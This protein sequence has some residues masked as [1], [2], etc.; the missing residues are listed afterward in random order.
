MTQLALAQT[1]IATCPYFDFLDDGDNHCNNYD[2]APTGY[3]PLGE[4]SD[5][6]QYQL[7]TVSGPY[8]DTVT[9]AEQSIPSLPKFM[10]S[11]QR[12]SGKLFNGFAPA[13]VAV[14]LGE[15][16]STTKLLTAEDVRRRLGVPSGTR[17][18][19]LAYGKD[20]LIENI[21]PR[22]R[23][24][25]RR[26][27]ELRFDL[28]TSINYSIWDNHPHPEKIFN[29]KRSLIIYE[30]MQEFGMPTVPHIYW[31][32]NKTMHMWVEWL[33]ANTTVEMVAVDAQTLTVGDWPLFL[34]ELETFQ[35]L[36]M[37]PVHF[38]I[39]GPESPSRISELK[40]VLP[41]FTLTNSAPCQRAWHR[42]AVNYVEGKIELSRPSQDLTKLFRHNIAVFER[43]LE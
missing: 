33:R 6:H 8:L 25:L 40:R 2:M 41:A 11:V 1:R 29:I 23:D 5:D 14:Q 15:V 9:A 3:V 35:Q 24:V 7:A 36:L 38:I 30:E 28:V 21:W 32:S 18:L 10:P 19:L 4:D 43:L 37:R 39:T 31:F 42:A 17:V 22:R 12:G 34:H 26:L 20:A 27:S 16:V 13:W